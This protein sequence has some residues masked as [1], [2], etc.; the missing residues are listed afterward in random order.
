[1]GEILKVEASVKGWKG[2]E[3]EIFDLY[4]S[5]LGVGIG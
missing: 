2:K 3:A 1:M 5:F 4:S